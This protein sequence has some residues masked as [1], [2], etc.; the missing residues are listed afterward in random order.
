MSL[1]SRP[2]SPEESSKDDSSPGDRS[3]DFLGDVW[4]ASPYPCHHPHSPGTVSGILMV[5]VDRH[6]ARV[7]HDGAD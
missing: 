7:E 6:Q 4:R 2:L 1:P 5:G 3:T